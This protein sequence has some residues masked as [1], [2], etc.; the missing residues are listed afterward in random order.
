M[1]GSGMSR[2]DNREREV[3]SISNGLK[4][5]AKELNIPVIVLSQLNRQADQEGGGKP[6]LSN[7]RESGAIEQDADVVCLLARKDAYDEESGAALDAVKA[8]VIVAKNRNGPVGEIKL[9]F[10]PKY[11]R[12]EDA[13]A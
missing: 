7:L 6:K 8:E 3:A 1:V 13:A 9:T 2:S 4:A 12:F 10:F 5:L 11:T